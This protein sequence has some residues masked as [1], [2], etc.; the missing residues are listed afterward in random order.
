M[1]FYL[2]IV[3]ALET[4]VEGVGAFTVGVAIALALQTAVGADKPK[5]TFALVWFSASAMHAP[6]W[7]HWHATPAK[8]VIKG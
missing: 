8:S 1:K 6:F 3:E 5:I 7:T 2:S 4:L